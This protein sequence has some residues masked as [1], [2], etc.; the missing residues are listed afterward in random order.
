MLALFDRIRIEDS[1]VRDWFRAVLVSQSKDA[2]I[3]NLAKRAELQRQETLL[4]AK[5]DRLLNLR[6]EGE[7]D[8]ATFARKQTEMRDRLAAIK[9]QVNALDRSHDGV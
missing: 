8:E 7:I 5:R 4:F 3:E 6:I 2:Q 1:S 9:L